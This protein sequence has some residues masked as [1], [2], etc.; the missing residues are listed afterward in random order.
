MNKEEIEKL[1]DDTGKI[2]VTFDNENN[3]T[4]LSFD[5][6]NYGYDGEKYIPCMASFQLNKH[7]GE[8]SAPD[9]FNL[10]DFE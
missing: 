3:I 4:S 10:T 5:M 8:F 6:K 2:V 9:W 7:V 1:K